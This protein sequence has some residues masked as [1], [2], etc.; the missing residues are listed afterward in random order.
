MAD[1]VEHRGGEAFGVGG[2]PAG[3]ELEGFGEL[4]GVGGVDAGPW[5]DNAGTRAAGRRGPG[6]G[7]RAGPGSRLL[8]AEQGGFAGDGGRGLLLGPGGGGL[9]GAGPGEAVGIGAG[10]EV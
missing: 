9:G 7:S 1:E 2:Q 8:L 6:R 4:D 5:H 3:D 10:L